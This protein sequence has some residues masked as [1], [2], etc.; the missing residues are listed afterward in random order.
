MMSTPTEQPQN[1]SSYI[2]DAESAAEMARLVSQ[3]RLTTKSMGGLLPEQTDLS[4]IHR[5]LDVACG[6]GGWVLDMAFEHPEV[7]VVGIDIS[8]R[9]EERRVGKECRSRWSPYH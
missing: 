7:Q 3:D 8:Q 6:P 9:S 1:E 5:V 2:I 4:S